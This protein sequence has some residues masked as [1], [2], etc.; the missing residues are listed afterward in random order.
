MLKI[1]ESDGSIVAWGSDVEGECSVPLQ[2][3]DSAFIAAGKHISS[4]IRVR[5]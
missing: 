2:N 5:F 3:G 4:A 1:A